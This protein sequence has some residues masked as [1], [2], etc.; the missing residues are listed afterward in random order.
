MNLSPSTLYDLARMALVFAH[1]VSCAIAVGFAFFADFR[2]LKARGSLKPRDNEVVQQVAT[3]VAGALVALWITGAGII[4]MD[5]GHVP[6]FEEIL[7][8][9][10]V[11]AKIFVVSVLTL[12][13]VLLH[14]Y[15]LPR[16][17]KIDLAASMLGGASATSWVFAI[18]LGVGKPLAPLLSSGEFIALYGLAL[19]LGMAVAGAVHVLVH[20]TQRGR[21]D[22]RRLALKSRPLRATVRDFSPEGRQRLT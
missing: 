6:S 9:P 2:V 14:A 8:R 21:P 4:L 11:A 17:P 5:V 10:K 18:F 20:T 1:V 22:R 19:V 3:F 7:A 12:N 13:G 15:A 16:L